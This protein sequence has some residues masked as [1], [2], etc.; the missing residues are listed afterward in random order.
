MPQINPHQLSFGGGVNAVHPS[1][2]IGEDEVQTATNIDFSLQRGAASVRRG[3]VKFYDVG[4]GTATSTDSVDQIFRHYNKPAALDDS[5]WYFNLNGTVYRSLAGTFTLLGTG[6]NEIAGFSSYRDFAYISSGAG[7]TNNIK[8]DG[9][10]TTEWIKQNPTA[11][12][13]VAV[14][15]LTAA[16]VASTYT[17]AEGTATSTRWATSA[18]LR[19]ALTATPTSTNLNLNG[20]YTIGD[21]GVDSLKILFS[22]PS[23]VKRVSRDYSIA[24]T[25]FTNYWHTE[26]PLNLYEVLDF[27]VTGRG[28]DNAIPNSSV[29]IQS[30]LNQGTT[31]D[32]NI[33]LEVRSQMLNDARRSIRAAKMRISAGAETFNAWNVPRTEFELVSLEPSPV[34]W[35]NI[36]AVRIVVECSAACEIEIGSWTIQGAESFPLN[37]ADVGYA[38]WET[39]AAFESNTLLLGE[40]APSPASAR[41]KIQGGQT[42]VTSTNTATGTI[43]GLTHRI[44]YR[45]GGYL[46]DA[47]AVAT[48]ALATATFTD[49]MNDIQALSLNQRME[50]NLWSHALFPNNL[51]YLAEVYHDRI[52]GGYNNTLIWSLPGRPDSF[53]K[54]SVT[55]VS[56]VGDQ[57]KG[58]VVWA[59]VLVIINRDSVYELQGDVFEGNDANWILQRTGSRRGSLT[60]R[61]AIKTPYGIPLVNPDGLYMY[62]PGQ[63]ID[64]PLTWAMEKMGDAFKGTATTDPAPYK[65]NRIPAI[66]Y[67][68]DS[69]MAFADDKLFF[70]TA[71]GTSTVNNTLFVLD[72]RTKQVW[73]Y[74]YPFNIASLFWDIPNT[75]LLA[76]TT[77]GKVMRLEIGTQDTGTDGTSTNITYSLRSR[78]WTTPSDTV[79]ENISVEHS[80][81]NAVVKGIYDGTTTATLGT[82]T[83][84]VRD[85]ITPPMSGS[86]T[87]NVV[88]DFSGTQGSGQL[89]NIYNIQWD[90]LVEPK[91]VEFW[92]TEHDVNDHDGEKLWD[93]HFAD[94]EIIG[95]STVAVTGTVFVDNTAVMT[96]T[97]TGPTN[98]RE[99]YPNSF[100]A[101]TFG[102]VAYTVYRA[103]SGLLFKHWNTTFDARNEPPRT[104]VFKSD[105]TSL[106]ENI[107]DAMDVDIDPNGTVVSTVYV[108]STSVG[109]YTSIGTGGRQSF[110]HALPNAGGTLTAPHGL[111]G[112][113][114]YALHNK[115]AGGAMKHYQTWFHLRP[116]PD[117]WTNFVST[118]SSGNEQF[119]QT[120]ECD[121]DPLGG[122]IYGTVVIDNT[123]VA[124]YTMSGNGRQSFP[125]AIPE[126][127]YGRTIYT[128]YA[129][130]GTSKFKHYNTWFE[131]RPEPDRLSLV[132]VGPY[133]YPS[134]QNLRTWIVDLNPLGTC[135]AIL[136]VDHSAL[137]TATFT[138]TNR[139]VFNVGLDVNTSIALQTSAYEVDVV[140]H[141][142]GASAKVKHYD[143]KFETEPK[144]FGKTTWSIT[145]KKVGGATQL[146]FARFWSFDIES[147]AVSTITSIWDIDGTAFSTNTYTLATATRWHDR[148][149]FPP[150][151]RGYLFQQRLLASSNIKVWKSNLDILRTGIKGLSRV[152]LPGTPNEPTAPAE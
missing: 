112:R 47:Y 77:D 31:T 37:D 5:P 92:R 8:D 124:T 151:G 67:L 78:A 130:S 110:T 28:N 7:G 119:W 127:K 125:W 152:T 114:I 86:V 131:G 17:A 27:D 4:V 2:L 117:R 63:G 73:W 1:H 51:P 138:G 96:A 120:F 70:A 101:N 74:T 104:T 141:A 54:T 49:S 118:R 106:E 57:I 38:W 24:D 35:T 87:N 123:A 40:S 64:E 22:N 146:D 34:G 68:W 93:V 53:P 48:L 122:T 12:V 107:C 137:S 79:L 95:T 25:N 46:A 76:G 94:L 59:P 3:S 29:L 105:I 99:I 85:W 30:Q 142:V 82:L 75:R 61:C 13:T 111:Y 50:R 83:G 66:N 21:W 143:T 103:A 145:Y 56:H 144:P 91:R 126:D 80:A 69:A 6:Y 65:G 88:F 147:T 32:T 140:Y 11:A 128:A 108:D 33:D 20:T 44:F 18:D 15:T 98:G 148:V 90:A 116:E 58:L 23:V 14:G 100:P 133:M 97:Y 62:I 89:Q 60:L 42:V 139:T 41:L 81:Q 36:A 136:Y 10:T 150:A 102:D 55:T 132:Q 121:I 71:T 134:S 109:T 84:T 129:G 135:T 45:Q 43:H 72:F 26:M 16:T 115:G 149:P 52:F 113:T 9:T 19:I 39:F